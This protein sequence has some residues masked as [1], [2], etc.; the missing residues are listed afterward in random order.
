[1]QMKVLNT[2]YRLVDAL[3]ALEAMMASEEYT[4]S[5]EAIL[6][7]NQARQ[8]IAGLED[9]AGTD[10]KTF[11]GNQLKSVANNNALQ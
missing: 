2:V 10:L 1:M 7:A 8:A 9:I 6:C 4:C 5:L 3:E 11:L